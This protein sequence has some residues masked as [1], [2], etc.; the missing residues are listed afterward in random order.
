MSVSNDVQEFLHA[1]LAEN[2]KALFDQISKLVADS[3]E[4]IKRSSVEAADDQLREIK[5]LRRE[6]PKL[7]KRKGNKIQYKFNLKLRIPWMTLNPTS[8]PTQL[9]KLNLHCQKVCQYFLR[10]KSLFY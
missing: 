4:S 2:N 1:S 10:G 7:F 6:E 8:S 9:T 5:K 3:V